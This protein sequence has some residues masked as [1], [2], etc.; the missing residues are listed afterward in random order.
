MKPQFANVFN[1]SVNDNRSECSLSFYHMYM[2]HN[3]TPQPKGL[4]DMPE[5]TVGE[6]A[7]I[8]LTRDGA[9][10]LTRLLSESF[11]LPEDN[12]CRWRKGGAYP[13]GIRA[14]LCRHA[15]GNIGADGRLP[16][17][18]RGARRVGA[19][20]RHVERDDRAW[21][22]D[23]PPLHVYWRMI[24]PMRWVLVGRGRGPLSWFW[25]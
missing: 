21:W 19:P 15:L 13:Q 17:A 4:I 16:R 7:S 10:A 14:A 8:M 3:Y 1:V 22:A 9:H 6:V 2:Q 23:R 25:D 18:L 5:K 24:F 12:I 11:G 20:R